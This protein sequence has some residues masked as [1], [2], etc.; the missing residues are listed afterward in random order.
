[1]TNGN[2]H[3]WIEI[4]SSAAGIMSGGRRAAMTRKARRK[5]GRPIIV[6]RD[7]DRDL[8]AGARNAAPPGV[9]VVGHVQ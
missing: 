6:A 7:P 1:M 9:T 5:I 3:C 4:D 8:V 2:S